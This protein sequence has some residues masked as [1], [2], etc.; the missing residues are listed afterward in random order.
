[1]SIPVERIDASS[2]QLRQD[3]EEL[4]VEGDL[5][6]SIDRFGIKE[7]LR[8]F[9]KEDG[10]AELIDGHRRL[11]AVL[12]LLKKYAGAPDAAAQ[13][14]A[15]RFQELACL[16]EETP[17]SVR[18]HLEL[19]VLLNAVRK[20][21]TPV[22]LARYLRRIKELEPEMTQEQL[23]ELLPREKRSQGYVSRL[24]KLA[25]DDALL[26]RV[27]NHELT[28]TEAY[29]RVAKRKKKSK[30]QKGKQATPPAVTEG[31]VRKNSLPARG[32]KARDPDS[33]LA[34][35]VLLSWQDKETHVNV[36][37]TG[38]AQHQ[39]NI[40]FVLSGLVRRLELEAKHKPGN[41]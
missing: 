37:V 35:A 17:P 29:Q 19:Q 38:P 3:F 1:M 25:Q 15:A 12:N 21:L 40:L 20:N 10:R 23:G 16:V 22:E 7:P 11:S 24:L 36:T 5:L 4:E 31:G 2:L 33:G 26:Q 18:K 28:A 14:K 6:A 8:V 41:D 32:K 27:E 34:D 30:P 39:Q 9:L 13:S